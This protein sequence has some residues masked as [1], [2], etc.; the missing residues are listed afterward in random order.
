[1][2]TV[3][4]SVDDKKVQPLLSE[5]DQQRVDSVIYSGTHSVERGPFRPFLLM[6]ILLAILTVLSFFSY[7]LAKWYGV[8]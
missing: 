4:H 8:I 5:Q 7:G 6:L 3:N 1:M 2:E